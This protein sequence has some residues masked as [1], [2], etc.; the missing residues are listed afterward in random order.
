MVHGA[1]D[2]STGGGRRGAVRARVGSGIT[3]AYQ[4]CQMLPEPIHLRHANT[5][6]LPLTINAPNSN[7]TITPSSNGTSTSNGDGSH[8]SYAIGYFAD[9]ECTQFVMATAGTRVNVWQAELDFVESNSEKEEGH[10]ARRYG[11]SNRDGESGTTRKRDDY[12]GFLRI[13]R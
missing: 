10:E 8:D 9:Q 4:A 7:G 1:A 6:L 13:A 11:S 5:T 2:T 3:L 12:G